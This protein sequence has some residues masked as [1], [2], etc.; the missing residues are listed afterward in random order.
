MVPTEEENRAEK[1]CRRLRHRGGQAPRG[2]GL[3]YVTGKGP[4][5]STKTTL[6]EAER[7]N[8]Q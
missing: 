3:P 4:Q 5:R 6:L 7:Q 2:L 8:R 1:S